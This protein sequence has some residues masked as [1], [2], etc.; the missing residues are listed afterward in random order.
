MELKSYWLIRTLPITLRQ[1]FIVI[2]VSNEL[3]LY[4]KV[5]DED[6]KMAADGGEV[7]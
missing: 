7:L 2:K 5:D 4:F 3:P 1:E 6:C